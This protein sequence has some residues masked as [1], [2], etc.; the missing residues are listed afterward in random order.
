MVLWSDADQVEYSIDPDDLKHFVKESVV[1]EAKF[2]KDYEG[3]VLNA[4]TEEEIL[5][6]YPDANSMLVKCHTFLVS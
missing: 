1:T 3:D 2:V 5:E 4:E 6:V